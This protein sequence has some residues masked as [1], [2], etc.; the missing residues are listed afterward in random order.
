M[1]VEAGWFGLRGIVSSI[2]PHKTMK[3]PHFQ[4][5]LRIRALMMHSARLEGKLS[6]PGCHAAA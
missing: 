1:R 4:S 5:R 2:S 3:R 6:V